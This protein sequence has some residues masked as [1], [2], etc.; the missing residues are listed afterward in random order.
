MAQ[1]LLV[2]LAHPISRGVATGALHIVDARLLSY[3]IT[4]QSFLMEIL[5]LLT[6]GVGPQQDTMTILR[7]SS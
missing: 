1:E 2:C 5:L 3:S 4:N 6:Q 7:N